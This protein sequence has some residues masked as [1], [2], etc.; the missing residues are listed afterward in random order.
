MHD[1]LPFVPLEVPQYLEAIY[2]PEFFCSIDPESSDY[3]VGYMNGIVEVISYLR[4][5]AERRD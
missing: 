4:N 5:L 2:T 3:L 1:E